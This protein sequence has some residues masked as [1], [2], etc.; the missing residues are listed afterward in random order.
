M[1]IYY[2][3]KIVNR[4]LIETIWEDHYTFQRRPKV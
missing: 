3:L 1:S 2:E 4:K